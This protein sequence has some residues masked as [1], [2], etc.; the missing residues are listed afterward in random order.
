MISRLQVS[1]RFHTEQLQGLSIGVQ[2]SPVGVSK[3]HLF[4]FLSSRQGLVQFQDKWLND[5]LRKSNRDNNHHHSSTKR[6]HRNLADD[7][8]LVD[9]V[10]N[11]SLDHS[12]PGCACL[13][14]RE[15]KGQAV[16]VIIPEDEGV[17]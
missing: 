15:L 5:I 7:S 17:R 9:K 16:E 4:V 3:I 13:P 8:V 1:H 10:S 2:E 12:I 6:K 14:V 11:T